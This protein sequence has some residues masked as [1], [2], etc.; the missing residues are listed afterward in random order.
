M[1]RLEH[2]RRREAQHARIVARADEHAVREQTIA[3]L[4]GVPSGADHEAKQE[5]RAAHAFDR[6][7]QR[8]T[9]RGSTAQRLR[10]INTSTARILK[11]ELTAAKVQIIARDGQT[12]ASPREVSG[13]I[14]LGPAQRVDLM[15]EFAP[16]VPAELNGFGGEVIARFKTS[17]PGKD[18][19]SPVLVPA[20]LPV[21]DL[22]TIRWIPGTLF[23]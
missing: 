10:L 3:H 17:G 2:E 6:T 9:T 20:D 4:L 5:S 12:L 23:S 7:A 13:D 19:A 11:L 1:A 15:T 14:L 18:Q 8:G 22:A 16:D 21:P